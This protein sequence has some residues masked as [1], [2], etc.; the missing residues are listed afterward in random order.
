MCRQI[1]PGHMEIFQYILHPLSWHAP[2]VWINFWLG[3][4]KWLRK[5]ICFL[6]TNSKEKSYDELMKSGVSWKWFMDLPCSLCPCK[7]R[8][9]FRWMMNSTWA[10]E[11]CSLGRAEE[12]Q[13]IKVRESF[14]CW[15]PSM[16]L[17]GLRWYL[18]YS[19]YP[20]EITCWCIPPFTLKFLEAEALS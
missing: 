13:L 16:S 20:I 5:L 14:T 4:K 9:H 12:E 19:L 11:M 8:K 2:G 18:Y 1:S 15:R 3:L 7:W 6:K 17:Q 10:G